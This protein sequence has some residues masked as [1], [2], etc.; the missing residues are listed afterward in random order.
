[1]FAPTQIVHRLTLPFAPATLHACPFA[2]SFA[3][4]SQCFVTQYEKY[5]VEGIP[6]LHLN[7]SFV[8]QEN[9]ADNGGIR[10]SWRAYREAVGG[11]HAGRAA[12]IVKG[13]TNDQL[14][15]TQFAQNWC[16][17]VRVAL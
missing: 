1:L 11:D 15:F 17:K 12:S 5:D 8:L 14:F 16:F 13:L 2:R 3:E 10:L 4:R 6:G 7:G 9:I